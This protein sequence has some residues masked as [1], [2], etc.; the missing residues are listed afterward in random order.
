MNTL[1]DLCQ[2]SGGTFE[3]QQLFK[4]YFHV[5]HNQNLTKCSLCE[6]SSLNKEKM[7]NHMRKHSSST[8][9]TPEKSQ[10][11]DVQMNHYETIFWFIQPSTGHTKKCV[12]PST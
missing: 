11:Q 7:Y 9:A 2:D 1:K 12:S 6:E 3:T 10:D 4:I 8:R 5:N